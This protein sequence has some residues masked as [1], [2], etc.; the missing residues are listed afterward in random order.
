MKNIKK[1]CTQK[2]IIYMSQLT[3]YS[4]QTSRK[5]LRILAMYF[6]MEGDCHVSPNLQG[7]RAD[8]IYRFSESI[9]KQLQKQ[10]K[11][12]NSRFPNYR[13]ARLFKKYVKSTKEALPKVT[14]KVVK[15]SH[16][17]FIFISITLVSSSSF[18][19]THFIISHF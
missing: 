5:V 14:F 16:L 4:Q 6:I 19:E 8:Y 17:F 9:R 7:L 3:S 2:T 11:V 18:I 10:N 13:R 12:Q 15:F 1:V